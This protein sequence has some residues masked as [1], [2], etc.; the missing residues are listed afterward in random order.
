MIGEERSL[1][2]CLMLKLHNWKVNTQFVLFAITICNNMSLVISCQ[3]AQFFSYVFLRR[4]ALCI[5]FCFTVFII[6]N[7]YRKRRR[8][9]PVWEIR[10]IRGSA[11]RAVPEVML[12]KR[13]FLCLSKHHMDKTLDER[14][15][16]ADGK[17]YLQKRCVRRI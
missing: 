6:R 13:E 1:R 4:L 2:L 17:Q 16:W 7:H 5:R 11:M 9:L 14:K 15:R 10:A 3:I 12:A 8:A